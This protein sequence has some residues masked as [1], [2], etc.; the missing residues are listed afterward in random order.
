MIS[1]FAGHIPDVPDAKDW[2][3]ADSKILTFRRLASTDSVD[4]T[5]YLDAVQ[6]QLGGSCV[7]Q[8]IASAAYLLGGISG[9]PI[10]RPSALFPYTI[11]RLLMLP[12]S[13]LVDAGCSPRA[14]MLGLRERGLVAADRWPETAE[15]LNEVPPFDAFREGEN[16]T[17]EA[18]YRI[19]DDAGAADA[20]RAALARGY[21]PIFGMVVDSKYEQTGGEVYATPG[22]EALGGH[23]QVVIGY[24]NVLRAFRI[25]NS[26]GP[27]FG[28]GG[29]SWIA[30]DF[31][32]KRTFDKWVLQVAPEAAR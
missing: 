18:F 19:D 8:S 14:A 2:R 26:W 17:I 24:S 25:L 13:A 32:A 20:L 27:T 6:N 4:Y 1:R 12:G 23:C 7:G 10:A 31:M 21:C 16:A 28:D 29:F 22:G 30:E 11:A 5:A 9:S 15:T 3:F